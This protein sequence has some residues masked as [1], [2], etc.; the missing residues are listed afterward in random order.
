MCIRDRAYLIPDTQ[1]IV[2]IKVMERGVLPKYLIAE[3]TGKPEALAEIAILGKEVERSAVVEI[4]IE[5][6]VNA[7]LTGFVGHRP[8]IAFPER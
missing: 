4:A 5:L 3:K 7:V 2:I 6:S 8:W 1:L